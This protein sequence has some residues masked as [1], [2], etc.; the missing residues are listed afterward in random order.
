MRLGHNMILDMRG[1]TEQ[2]AFYTTYDD[3]VINEICGLLPEGGRF[4][5]VGANIG[6]F[7]IPVAMA[8]KE[9]HCN[10]LA[11]EPVPSNFKM[12]KQNIAINGLEDVVVAEQLGLSRT[13]GTATITLRDYFGFGAPTGNTSILID[14]GDDKKWPKIDVQLTR[15]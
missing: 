13:R 15:R 14:D 1:E 8:W 3:K 2:R 9:K 7:S 11:F 6:F 10:A 12:L 5:D 4:L